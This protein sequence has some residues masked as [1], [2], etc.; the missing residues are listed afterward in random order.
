MA[1]FIFILSRVYGRTF[2]VS[3]QD[4]RGIFIVANAR[5]ESC[6]PNDRMAIG[7]IVNGW[8]LHFLL[9]L[10]TRALLRFV[11]IDKVDDA[12]GVREGAI[13]AATNV[14]NGFLGRNRS[15]AGDS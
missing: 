5:L 7:C 12:K 9:Q 11:V 14:A 15:K 8:V 6:F 4:V 3:E 13:F 2:D 10:R 1:R